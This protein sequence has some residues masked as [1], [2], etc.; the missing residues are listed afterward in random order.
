VQPYVES[1]GG[2]E[3]S[4]NSILLAWSEEKKKAVV[5]STNSPFYSPFLQLRGVITR[6]NLVIAS[7]IFSVLDEASSRLLLGDSVGGDFGAADPARDSLGGEAEWLEEDEGGYHDAAMDAGEPRLDGDAKGGDASRSPNKLAKAQISIEPVRN[8]AKLL[9]SAIRECGDGA[10]NYARFVDSL[11]STAIGSGSSRNNMM[12]GVGSADT[13]KRC[14]RL[15]TMA[16]QL[17]YMIIQ[18]L[19]YI[20]HCLVIP[21]LILEYVLTRAK[22]LLAQFI[23]DL[24]A[25]DIGVMGPQD[26]NSSTIAGNQVCILT[27]SVPSVEIIMTLERIIPFL[28]I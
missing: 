1:R 12:G 20:H 27:F 5:L 4:A 22:A 2:D 17:E 10:N 9:E 13:G 24:A 19:R 7:R 15:E 6:G 18:T 8:A 21:D 14:G 28:C 11:S 25:A 16:R 3:A 23:S 26:E